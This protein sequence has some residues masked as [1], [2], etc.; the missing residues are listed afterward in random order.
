MTLIG[1]TNVI[2][3]LIFPSS[4]IS[5]SEDNTVKFWQIGAPSTDPVTIDTK[6]TPL[7]SASIESVSLQ[8]RDGVAI[9]SDQAGV[10]KTWDILTG[11]CKASFQTPAEGSI[12]RDV[13]LIEGRLIVIWH[14]GWKINIW[15]G[16]KGEFLQTVDAPISSAR[17][18]RIS[19]DGSKVFYLTEES[20]QAWSIWTGETIGKV[21]LKDDPWLDP[22]YVDGSKVWVCFK[23]SQTQGWDF[24]IPATS[25]IQLSNT[26]LDKTHLNLIG[27][28]RWS[29]GPC[30]IKDAVT[31]KEV[32]QLAGKYTN[33]GEVQW[34][35]QYLVVGYESGE[36]LILDFKHVLLQ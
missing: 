18:V 30:G 1:H 33:P 25:P 23:D 14:Q 19:G 5:A 7:T 36:V 20:I 28:T 6:P 32:F 26:S 12:W 17:G 29:T 13:Q 3:S 4:L 27:G 11:L 34:D 8:V 15:D 16:E 35:G 2:T 24:G 10:V 9:S 21:E 31:G 22:L